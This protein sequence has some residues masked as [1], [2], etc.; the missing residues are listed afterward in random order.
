MGNRTHGREVGKINPQQFL[1]DEFG[2]FFF[3]KMHAGYQGVRRHHKARTRGLEKGG[4][5]GEPR[6]ALASAG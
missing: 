6:R 2:G 1:G 3:G 5:V 4:V